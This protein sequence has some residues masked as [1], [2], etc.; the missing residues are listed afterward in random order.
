MSSQLPDGMA[1][2]SQPLQLPELGVAESPTL[3]IDRAPTTTAAV[4]EEDEV[5]IAAQRLAK[6]VNGELIRLNLE[7]VFPEAVTTNSTLPTAI[8]AT[9]WDDG[10]DEEDIEF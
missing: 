2:F 6:A 9:S 3:S 7:P 10:E 4:E 8:P 5:A 1:E